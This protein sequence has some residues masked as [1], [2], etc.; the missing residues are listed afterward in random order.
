M[1]GCPRAVVVL[2]SLAAAIGCSDTP[3]A[4]SMKPGPAVEAQASAAKAVAFDGTRAWTHLQKQVALGPRPSG[5]PALVQNRKYIVD[6]LKAIGIESSNPLAWS[7][8]RPNRL[9]ASV[10]SPIAAEIVCDPE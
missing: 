9:M 6:Q 8:G 10:E 4:R 7:A 2:A 5:T 3:E 1:R